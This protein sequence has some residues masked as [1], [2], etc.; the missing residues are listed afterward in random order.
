MI[1]ITLVIVYIFPRIARFFFRK[2]NDGIIQY[3]FVM[4]MLFMGAG[5]MELAGMEGILG[6]FITGLAL[7]RLIPHSSP[8]MKH[9]EFVGN[10]IFIPYFLI[11]VMAGLWQLMWHIK[12][13]SVRAMHCWWQE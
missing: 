5:I 4:A 9:I 10:A 8:L 3:I 11:G 12:F 7:N 1:A 2:Y 6:A 13:S